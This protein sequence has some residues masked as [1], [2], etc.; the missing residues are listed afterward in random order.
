[1][2][3]INRMKKPFSI[4]IYITQWRCLFPLSLA[5]IERSDYKFHSP[6]EKS[7]G[8]IDLTNTFKKRSECS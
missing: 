2:R 6:G 5:F 7:V 3:L 4:R 1:M 8:E